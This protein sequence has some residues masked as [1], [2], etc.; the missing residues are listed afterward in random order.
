MIVE[1][2][3]MKSWLAFPRLETGQVPNTRPTGDY[4]LSPPGLLPVFPIISD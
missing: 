3:G 1:L 4:Q 2:T